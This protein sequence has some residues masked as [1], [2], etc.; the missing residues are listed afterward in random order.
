[1]T[2]YHCKV[3]PEDTLSVVSYGNHDLMLRSRIGDRE[4]AIRLSDDDCRRLR[5]QL[6][7]HLKESAPLPVG[8][9][10]VGSGLTEA[11]K[12]VRNDVNPERLLVARRALLEGLT[13]SLTAEGRPFWEAIC[14][15]L[16]DLADSA[17]AEARRPKPLPDV[18]VAGFVVKSEHALTLRRL[19]DSP[20]SLLPSDARDLAKALSAHADAAE[21][22]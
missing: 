10:R 8:T 15:R 14:A 12:R 2:T 4:V 3:V 18:T 22:K 19:G 9:F 20:T 17:E 5:D 6:T 11:Q 21:K 13:F 7:A 1:M 16:G